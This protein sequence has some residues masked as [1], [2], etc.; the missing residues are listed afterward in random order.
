MDPIELLVLLLIAGICGAV[1][2]AISGYTLGG[3]LVSVGLGFIGALIGLW[4]ARGL[5]L[6]EPLMLKVGSSEF[7]VVWSIVGSTVFVIL[8]ALIRRPAVTAN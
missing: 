5:K 6:Y 3:L 7:P 4:M 8:I 2:Q 1:G